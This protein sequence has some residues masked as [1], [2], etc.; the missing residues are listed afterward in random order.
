ASLRFCFFFGCCSASPRFRFPAGGCLFPRGGFVQRQGRKSLFA[1]SE[2]GEAACT[3]G[4]LRQELVNAL[5]QN[6]S[7]Q[8]AELLQRL[9]EAPLS[10][11]EKYLQIN[12]KGILRA[13]V[14]EHVD[15]RL[16]STAFQ[17]LEKYG[18]N[19]LNPRKPYFWRM[20]KFNNPV[21]RDTVD[22]IQGGRDVLRLYGYSEQ[23]AD[24]LY[25][26]DPQL[27]P[28][29]PQ[30]ASVTVDVMLLRAELTLV[31]SETHPNPQVLQ[32]LMGQGLQVNK[33]AYAGSLNPLLT[34]IR[35][36][37][38]PPDTCLL[39]GLEAPSQ[40]CAACNQSLCPNCDRLF[41]KHPSRMH[42]H[43]NPSRAWQ[44][45]P[46]PPNPSLSSIPSETTSLRAPSL[47]PL[48]SSHI[49]PSQ[50]PPWRCAACQKNNDAS[51]ILCINCDRPRG[52]KTPQNL[53]LDDELTSQ[54][55]L[56]RGRWSCQTCTF[57]NESATVLCAAPSW[58][59]DHCTFRN[60]VGR[61]ICEM[62]NCTSL[63]GDTQPP[64][65]REE[66]EELGRMK[67]EVVEAPGEPQGLWRA[68]SISPEEVEHQ[69]QE[70]LRDDGQKMVDM[71]REAETVGVAPEMVAAALCYSGA[72]LPLAWL[73]SELPCVLEGMAELATQRGDAEPD[74]GLGA[75]T[76]QEV[77]TAWVAS[78]GDVRELKSLG[79]EE[80]GP[81][82]QALYEN[83]GDLWRALVQLQR[84]RLAP[85]H[86]RL[87]ES[88]DPPMNF[89]STDRQ[90][91][92]RGR[93]GNP[94][95]EIQWE[96][97]L[98]LSR[99]VL[100]QALLRRLL[101]SLSLPS[102]GR[103]ELVVSLMLEQPDEGWELS[104]IVEAVKASPNRD[105]IKR[106]LSWECAVC[107]LALPRNKE[108]HI[109]D[110]VCPACSE[111]EISDETELLNYFSTLDIQLRSCLDQE[112]YDLFHKKL[113][114][115]VLMQ[116]PKFQWCTHWEPQ[117]QGLTCE[118][119]L[120]W[121]RTND[122]EYQAQ[123]LAMYL[124]ENGIGTIS[125]VDVT[126]RFMP[127]IN[128]RYRTARSGGPSMDIT[129]V[130]ASSTCG[131]GVC[132]VCRSSSRWVGHRVGWGASGAGKRGD[133]NIAFNT[134]P[135]AGTRATP[136]GGCRVM[137]Q[138]ETLDGLKDE[139]CGKE[140]PTGYAGL[141]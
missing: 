9:V 74:G 99:L 20:V 115:H 15:L 55:L 67:R 16:I 23:K 11:D 119:F 87:W 129:R 1:R 90:V 7:E 83:N 2:M 52:C 86:Q 4:A 95:P 104:D 127:P 21:F 85:F 68:P 39:C 140:T 116:D 89:Q 12:A 43:R 5:I 103:A 100:R 62:C 141:C 31:L 42:H 84:V 125:A 123:G 36:G 94:G 78:R 57:E 130:T 29:I 139:P 19:L 120:E 69:R 38:L 33:M 14:K 132:H 70:K 137:E 134:D 92:G 71:I 93:E 135:P 13:N 138:K 114:E 53:G 22:T 101:A 136:G 44:S 64:L 50:R 76:L 110:L 96:A 75:I 72:E 48:S 102:W 128:A 17:I 121:K 6:P 112:T 97:P 8:N 60:S 109:T 105:F 117:H 54:G 63:H 77:Q 3:F 111:P 66:K 107:S 56:A 108:K 126:G 27:E 98:V 25:F 28:D 131:T 113:T 106:L 37:N 58:Q 133:N 45:P 73:K 91:S 88:E 10:L 65:A 79:F 47:P 26:P 49:I 80:R 34:M 61:R 41:H 40:H 35:T 46:P 32:E 82:L 124:Q 81:A 24:G 18:R 122:P 30:V 59:C 51:C 118:A